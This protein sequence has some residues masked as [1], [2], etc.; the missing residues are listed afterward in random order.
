MHLITRLLDWWQA[1]PDSRPYVAL[2]TAGILIIVAP[3]RIFAALNS[4]QALKRSQIGIRLIIFFP[5][6]GILMR[7]LLVF[8]LPVS[9][10]KTCILMGF[11]VVS[12]FMALADYQIRHNLR[13]WLNSSVLGRDKSY[14]TTDRSAVFQ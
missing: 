12:F 11:G 3:H 8:G 2:V 14:L 5:V 9:E 6:V 4:Q 13:S 7:L 1:L 10:T